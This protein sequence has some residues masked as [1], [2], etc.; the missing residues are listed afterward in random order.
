MTVEA[1]H[2]GDIRTVQIIDRNNDAVRE[3]TEASGTQAVEGGQRDSR[4][5]ELHD[6]PGRQN[7]LAMHGKH[8]DRLDQRFK[9]LV[10]D[11]EYRILHRDDDIVCDLLDRADAS[12]DLDIRHNPR[13][14]RTMNHTPTMAASMSDRK[15]AATSDQRLAISDQRLPQPVALQNL[16]S[17]FLK[18]AWIARIRDRAPLS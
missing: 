10:S 18:C 8:I 4:S 16:S 17:S 13:R 9:S 2:G 6:V 15:R 12:R 14:H 5:V 7:M 3:G 11:D 1:N